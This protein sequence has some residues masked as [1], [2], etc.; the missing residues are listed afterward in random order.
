MHS[1]PASLSFPPGSSPPRPLPSSPTRRSSD[2][3]HLR[4]DG[5]HTGDGLAA[6]LELRVGHAFARTV[7]G[8]PMEEAG[9]RK[10]TR[11]NSSHLGSS[12][13]VFCLKTKQ[14]DK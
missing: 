10:S 6:V 7:F 12:Y 5:H 1:S 2:L 4:R 13:A 8:V 3:P 9:D 11:L 14:N